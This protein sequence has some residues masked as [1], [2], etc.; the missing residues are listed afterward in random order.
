M[1]ANNESEAQTIAGRLR[2]LEDRVTRL[3]WL[4]AALAAAV[5]AGSPPDSPLRALVSGLAHAGGLT[6]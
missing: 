3:G 6:P 4:V 5:V 1:T 2:A